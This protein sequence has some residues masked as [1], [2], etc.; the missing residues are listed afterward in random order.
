M[1]GSSKDFFSSL[2]T[3]LDS[4]TDLRTCDS[5]LSY[6]TSQY[7]LH[8]YETPTNT[9]FVMLTDTKSG[10][11]RIALQQIYVNCYVEYVVKNPLSPVEH[12]GGIGV[13]NELFEASLEQFVVCTLSPGDVP[14]QSRLTLQ[15]RTEF[16]TQPEP[17]T[18]LSADQIRHLTRHSVVWPNGYP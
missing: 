14:G 10:S 15:S 13:N 1:T 9:K 2:C 3:G 5:F 6:R 18:I 12:P 17:V 16:S 8:Y 7:K 11:M 4:M